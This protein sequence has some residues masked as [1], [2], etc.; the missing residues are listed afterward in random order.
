MKR[1]NLKLKKLKEY[2]QEVESFSS[3]KDYY[4]QYQ[5]GYD[6]AADLVHYISTN[7]GF[8]NKIVADL[9]SGSGILGIACLLCGAEQVTFFEIDKDAIEDLKSNIEY[10]ELEEYSQIINTNIF[11]LQSNNTNRIIKPF[12]YTITNPPFGVQSI[13]SADVLFL[14]KAIDLTN[15]C[16]FSM[17]K[18]NTYEYLKKF[19]ENKGIKKI[20]KQEIEFDIPKTYKFH[21]ENN[22]IIKV[23][24]IEA[25]LI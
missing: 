22:K 16:I 7:F 19:Y 25:I 10:F 21:K 23:C 6:V 24:N 17:H 4:E 3:P 9:G 12:D 15:E 5:T 18:S 8:E 20:S 1:G 11:N 14:E 2:L 13:N